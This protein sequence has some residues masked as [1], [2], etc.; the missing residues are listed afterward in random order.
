MSTEQADPA[1]PTALREA[2]AVDGGGEPALGRE[3]VHAFEAA[4]GVVLPEPWR[5]HTASGPGFA[6]RVARRAAGEERFDGVRGRAR[7]GA[8]PARPG[9]VPARPGAVRGGPAWPGRPVSGR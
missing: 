6:G 2:F 7:P 4:H 3:T 9:A 5:S 1:E 8:V